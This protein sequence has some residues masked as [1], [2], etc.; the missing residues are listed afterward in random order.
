MQQCEAT[1]GFLNQVTSCKGFDQVVNVLQ[2]VVFYK[3][4]TGLCNFLTRNTIKYIK[5]SAT[6]NYGAVEQ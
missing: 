6:H 2:S 5:Y 3:L 4:N 1:H